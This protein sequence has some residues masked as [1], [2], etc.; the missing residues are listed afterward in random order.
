MRKGSLDKPGQS[1]LFLAYVAYELKDFPA[2]AGAARDAAAYDDVKKD[3]L[4]RLNQA[5][6]AATKE[7]I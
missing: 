1:R 6:A 5:I 7:K 4:A 3:D 2:A